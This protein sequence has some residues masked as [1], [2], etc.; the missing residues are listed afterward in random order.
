MWAHL[1]EAQMLIVL[2]YTNIASHT[3]AERL[4]E[5]EDARRIDSAIRL[6][7]TIVSGWYEGESAWGQGT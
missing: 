2:P 4:G 7:L 6:G 5:E 1:G 3:E